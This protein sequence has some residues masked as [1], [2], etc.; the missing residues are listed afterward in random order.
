MRNTETGGIIT[1]WLG[2][3]VVLM[4][5][6]GVLGHE[7]I[8]VAVTAINLEDDARDVAQSAARAYG[9]QPKLQTAQDA[10][11]QQAERLGVELVG[12]EVNKEDGTVVATVTRTADTLFI[13]ELGPLEDLA[14]RTTSGRAR[15]R[16]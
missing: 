8:T 11:A 13:H 10:A 4:A 15:W 14:T 2:Q 1:G 3:L 9:A 12:V 16:Q 6:L 5:V 7:A